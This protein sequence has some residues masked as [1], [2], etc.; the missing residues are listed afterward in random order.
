MSMSPLRI[1]AVIPARG[2]SKGIPYKNLADLGG[3][4]LIAWT[5]AAAKAAHGLDRIIVSTDDE[6][7]AASA[8]E[9]GAEVP[10][11]RPTEFSGDNAPALDVIL[12]ALKELKTP[13][14]EA[15]DAVAYL[16]PTSPFRSA[17]Q[18]TE[19]IALFGQERPDTLVSV[20]AVPHN[21]V[22]ASLMH[23]LGP[24][25]PLML[26]SPVGQKLRR[27]EKE[28]LFARNGPAILIVSASDAQLHGR[29]YGERVLGFEMDRLSSLDIDDPIDLE[30]ARHLLPLLQHPSSPAL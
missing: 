11:L 21:M 17:A 19:A 30:M 13:G 8:I 26:Q 1:A 28:K 29:L 16:Q 23:P 6:R 15:Y 9:H 12:H 22:P 3:R 10:F 5:I 18:L 4:P 24:S 25:A 7:I 27:Q 20:T 14:G 2:G